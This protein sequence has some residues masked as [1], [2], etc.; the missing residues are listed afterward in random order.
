[1]RIFL[2]VVLLA[3]CT[4]LGQDYADLFKM[5]YAE[6]FENEFEGTDATTDVRTVDIDLT[7]PIVLNEQHTFVTGTFFGRNHLQLYPNAEATS[8][9]ST[10]LKLGLQSQWS[11]RWSTTVVLLPK[12]ASDYHDITGDDF[13]FGGFAT[14]KYKKNEHLTWRFGLYASNEAFG[15]FMTPIFGW[16]YLSPNK[17]FE[18]NMSLPISADMNY[19]MGDFAVGLDYFGIGRSFNIPED[20]T[21]VDLSSLDFAGYLQY[22]ILKQSILLRAKM[23]YSSNDFEVYQQGETVD[24]VVSAFTF[25]DDR[26]QLNPTIKGGIFFKFEAIYRFHLPGEPKAE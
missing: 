22:G 8:L 18:M 10:T 1:M 4:L 12:I 23:G 7:I 9:Y 15:I 5:G 17:K 6:T 13:Y 11:E 19:R 14:A 2:F 3:P 24:L 21:Y 26:T 25:G 20:N 16:Y